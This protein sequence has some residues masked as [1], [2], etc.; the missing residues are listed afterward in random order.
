MMITDADNNIIAINPAFTQITGYEFEDVKNQN[1][2]ML[3]SG[4]HDSEFFQSLWQELTTTGRWQGEIWDK[5]K[6]EEVYAKWLTINAIINNDGSIQRYIAL[7]SDITDK[8]R[9]EEVIWKQANYDKVTNLPNRNMF[10]DRLEQE[11]RKSDRANE[12]LA[13][14]LID[15]DQFKEVNDTL[16]HDV[17]DLLLQKVGMRIRDCVRSTDTVAR[18]GGDEFTIIL[19]DLPSL[20]KVEVIAQ[21]I[22]DRLAEGYQIGD[23]AIHISGSIGITLYPDDT[24]S[25]DALIKNADQAM[26]AAKEKGRNCFS[27]FTQSLQDIAKNRLNLKNDLRHAIPNDELSVYFQPI[28]DL[29]SG[30]IIKAEALLRWLH[31]MRGMVGPQDFIPLTEETGL[32]NE[33]GDWVF[34][35]SVRW[36]KRWEDLL[37]EDFQLSI[38][39]SPVQFRNEDESIASQWLVYLNEL[40]LSGENIVIEITESLLLNAESNVIDKLYHF[41]D[42]GIQVAIDDFGTGYSSLAYLKKFDIDILKIDQTFVRNLETDQNDIALSE[43][44][45][46]MAHKL[47]LKVVAEGV[48]TDGQ[49]NILRDAGCDFAQ[50]YLFSRPIQPNDFEAILKER[51]P[52]TQ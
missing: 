38:N 26:Y 41:R 32:I 10:H 28:I 51:L 27:Y 4:R 13:L 47:G 11:I 17:G 16:G 2:S 18:L 6:N 37:E 24:N 12:P 15:L 39:M 21:K 30:K 46:V 14:L 23:H 48:E 25:I 8:K 3:N 1:P 7:F 40:G 20:S 43:A 44:I 52:F 19:T 49:R 50:G 31:P 5:R 45:I 33:I 9:S 22:V 36:V 42:A 34:R 35:E 29:S